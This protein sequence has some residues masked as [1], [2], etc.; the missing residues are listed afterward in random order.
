MATKQLRPIKIDYEYYDQ[1]ERVILEILETHIYAPLV[2][3]LNLKKSLFKNDMSDLLDAIRTGR[4][5][6]WQG[7]FQG[8][9]NA[10]LTKELR[11]LGAVRDGRTGTYKIRMIDLPADIRIAI[12]ASEDR[13]SKAMFRINQKLNQFD[14]VSVIGDLRIE[15]FFDKSIYKTEVDIQKTLKNITVTP[16]L[17]DSQREKISEGYTENLNRYIRKFTD[18]QILDLRKKIQTNTL[19]GYR[20]GGLVKSL[21]DSYGV[22]QNK[23][24]FL[25]RQETN[26]M[27]QEFKKVRYVDAGSKGYHWGCVAGSPDHPVRQIHKALENTYILW[28]QPPVTDIKGNRNHA[29]C[30]YNCRCFPKVVISF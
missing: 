25:A 22:S 7:E 8:T 29:G 14:S 6:F 28:S 9:L 12:A 3:E 30:D 17:T 10:T 19:Q 1:L 11:R 15:R 24:K 2:G 27:M 5:T 4:L 16:E 23:A 18:E 13:F 26:L 20:F 21:Q